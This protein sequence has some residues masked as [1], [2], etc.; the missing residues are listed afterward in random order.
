MKSNNFGEL[1]TLARNPDL[2]FKVLTHIPNSVVIT[3]PDGTI[4]FVNPKFTEITGY[5]LD[6]AVGHNPRILQSGI[7]E[8]EVFVSLWRTITSGHIWQGKL[9]NSKKNGE[10][11]VEKASIA[12]VMDENGAIT[13]YVA[14]KEDI[15]ESLLEEKALRAALDKTAMLEARL[16]DAIENIP[17]SFVLYDKDGKLTL[18]N[19][20]FKKFYGYSDDEAR[21]GIHYMELGKIDVERGNVIVG[22]EGGDKYLEKRA[23]YRK[24][25]KGTFNVHLR[26]GRWL[27]TRDRRTSDGGIASIQTD[28]TD[29][30]RIEEALNITERNL[31]KA[32]EAAENA[33]RE[34]TE[35]LSGMSH[36]LRTPLNAIIGYSQFLQH[37]PNEPVSQTQNDQLNTIADSG[38]HLLELI[39]EI[40]DMSAMETGHF[41]IHPTEVDFSKVLKECLGL[42]RPSADDRGITISDRACKGEV[43]VKADRKRLK[44][45]F[46]NLLSNAVKYNRD[47]GDVDIA[48]ARQE[49][50]IRISITDTGP[51]IS[52]ENQKKLF[53]DYVRLDAENTDIQGSGLGLALCRRFMDM[54]DGRIGVESEPGKGS[55]FWFELPLIEK[56][57]DS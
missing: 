36:E 9:H 19:E 51:G 48:C 6:E 21:P 26:D 47:E 10:T 4:L 53:K 57:T 17:E 32:K 14:I 16:R 12:P 13:H 1:G 38:A 5:T 29:R 15:T 39:N 31:R 52:L 33:N 54:M 27:Q 43:F 35:F 46:L 24:H 50:C 55:T 28:I 2:M 44:Q 23:E 25:L 22:G 37:N 30:M 41:S 11:Y 34:K 20:N 56:E 18:C 3:D 40:L 42:I 7:T 45:V 49:G 8:P